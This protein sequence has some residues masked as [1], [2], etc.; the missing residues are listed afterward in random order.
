MHTCIHAVQSDECSPQGRVD[1]LR[2]L[3]LAI[4]LFGPSHSCINLVFPPSAFLTLTFLFLTSSST[5]SE[6]PQNPVASHSL[7][8]FHLSNILPYQSSTVGLWFSR[9]S[10]FSASSPLGGFTKQTASSKW[11]LNLNPE[12]WAF[13]PREIFHQERQLY[14][15]ADA[16]TQAH[17]GTPLSIHVNTHQCV[18]VHTNSFKE[19]SSC[20]LPECK[21]YSG[22]QT[23]SLCILCALTVD[24][25]CPWPKSPDE[26]YGRPFNFLVC[27]PGQNNNCSSG[28]TCQV[29]RRSRQN[30][31]CF[32]E[33]NKAA[34][35]SC[36]S[37]QSLKYDYG[38]GK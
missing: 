11:N 25:V 7:T 2:P 3:P 19:I 15:L 37:H 28:W 31:E 22:F 26:S 33:A 12:L 1:K 27:S 14:T 32:T 29:S 23:S 9:C 16:H 30:Q 8:L 10:S 20:L 5:H 38:N 4:L 35:I 21:F 18:C 6:P 24:I 34:T 13:L 36:P 17:R